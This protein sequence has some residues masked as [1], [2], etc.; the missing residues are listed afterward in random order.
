MLVN[1]NQL[2]PIEITKYF[3]VFCG[4]L[5]YTEELFSRYGL[6]EKVLKVRR[7]QYK[8]GTSKNFAFI[9]K[10][11][12]T[13]STFIYDPLTIPEQ[14]FAKFNLPTPQE[15]AKLFSSSIQRKYARLEIPTDVSYNLIKIEC[16]NALANADKYLTY[17]YH[18]NEHHPSIIKYARTYSV[19]RLVIK[20]G[21]DD[22][23]GIKSRV[24]D[25]L[26][27]DQ[28]KCL[29]IP[30]NKK[31]FYGYLSRAHKSDNLVQFVLGK[32]GIVSNHFKVNEKVIELICFLS[33]HVNN[34]TKKRI[35]IWTNVILI[36]F[37]SFNGSK[38]LSD[39]KV[40][41]VIDENE[42]R[43]QSLRQGEA[44]VRKLIVPYLD[45]IAAENPFDQFAFD[46]W[47]VEFACKN[48]SKRVR[49]ILLTMMDSCSRKIVHHHKTS[50]L[51]KE[52]I[53]KF[54]YE[55]IT[56]CGN[57][58]PAEIVCDFASYNVADE[59]KHAITYLIKTYKN[60]FFWS[61]SS[62]SNRKTF[63]ERFYKTFGT[64]YLSPHLG[65]TGEGIQSKRE[66]AHPAH[67]V[68]IYLNNPKYL[69]DVLEL[70][71]MI[72]TFIGQ[73]CRN[74]IHKSLSSPNEIF[75]ENKAVNAIQ[76]EDHEPVFMFF[77]PEKRIM[78]RGLVRLYDGNMT[79]YYKSFN[80]K[81]IEYT[82]DE[83]DCYPNPSNS[84]SVFV[85]KSG[86]SEFIS[87]YNQIHSFHGAKI[88]QTEEDKMI[89]NLLYTEREKMVE[90]IKKDKETIIKSLNEVTEG[91]QLDEFVEDLEKITL[92]TLSTKV[93][94]YVPGVKDTEPNPLNPFAIPEYKKMRKAGSSKVKEAKKEKE[95]EEN[96]RAKIM[97]DNL[98]SKFSG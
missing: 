41:Q 34:I 51:N 49:R 6:S 4:T 10:K 78:K 1:I 24:F 45:V 75:L 14:S 74:G 62:N 63:L 8:K 48:N 79:R 33:S 20:Y 95:M 29:N 66:N 9:R 46:E 13:E 55:T 90:A 76:L 67:V 97:R 30:R 86:T 52:V 68:E 12:Q 15:V 92:P 53:K 11:I 23:Y 32:I 60:K 73:Y 81:I 59:I 47:Y 70:D 58:A 2:K 87:T 85:F 57:R 27:E 50:V 21:G 17:F 43:I 25:V 26:Q 77:T 39:K 16:E 56:L 84:K 71:R 96:S 80:P 31:T 44:Y 91:F 98:R 64:V 89:Y 88:N 3:V 18:I 69:D 93:S 35:R 65:Y 22:D 36:A 83:V 38:I 82:N 28:F 94:D 7:S 19:L 37:P 54:L 72:D 61:V 5:Y 40:Q 42:H